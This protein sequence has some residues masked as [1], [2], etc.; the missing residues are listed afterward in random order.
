MERTKEEAE[1]FWEE[2][3]FEDKTGVVVESKNLRM[4]SNLEESGSRLGQNV[5]IKS[6]EKEEA[7]S[8]SES[9]LL[10]NQKIND[11]SKEE[12]RVLSIDEEILAAIKRGEAA[13]ARGNSWEATLAR[14]DKSQVETEAQQLRYQK[15]LQRPVSFGASIAHNV[16][17]AACAEKEV[18]PTNSSEQELA[19][20]RK[21]FCSLKATQSSELDKRDKELV[22]LKKEIVKLNSQRSESELIIKTRESMCI[23]FPIIFPS[24]LHGRNCCFFDH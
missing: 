16:G 2:K 6:D 13:M 3:K 23:D 5:S 4:E 9:V 1:S 12:V 7:K 14:I 15:L 10:K 18:L 21:E 24:P 8:F 17:D 22:S 19:E 11:S 20:L